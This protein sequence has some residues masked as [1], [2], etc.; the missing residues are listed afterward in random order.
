MMKKTMFSRMSA[1]LLAV[2]LGATLSACSPAKAEPSVQQPDVEILTTFVD[3]VSD[4]ITVAKVNSET[5]EVLALKTFRTD[6]IDGDLILDPVP[7][8]AQSTEGSEDGGTSVG[9]VAGDVGDSPTDDSTILGVSD[10]GDAVDSGASDSGGSAVVVTAEE[11]STQEVIN[12]SDTGMWGSVIDG[13]EAIKSAASKALQHVESKMPTFGESEPVSDSPTGT[14][15]APTV[16]SVPAEDAPIVPVE[17]AS[18]EDD[19][20]SAVSPEPSAAAVVLASADEAPVN[21]SVVSEDQ[22]S[23]AVKD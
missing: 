13:L 5:G 9:D 3:E 14:D 4:H 10:T 15:S 18:S 17:D 1:A 20:I 2:T 16:E 21:S 11:E 22:A 6:V 23:P 12:A 19:P 8:A 7:V